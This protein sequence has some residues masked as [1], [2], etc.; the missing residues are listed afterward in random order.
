MRHSD[1]SNF[2]NSLNSIRHFKIRLIVLYTVGDEVLKVKDVAHLTGYRYAHAITGSHFA[3]ELNSILRSFN[4]LTID[5]V[6]TYHQSR[7]SFASFAVDCSHTFR[8][9]LDK[10]SHIFTESQHHIERWGVVVIKSVDLGTLLE[11]F[12]FVLLLRA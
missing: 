10:L 4:E 2:V 9:P 3:I 12:F 11:T 1:H 8:I 6:A 5:K 7:P